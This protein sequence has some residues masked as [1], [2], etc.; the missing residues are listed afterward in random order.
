[1]RLS[2][3]YASVITILLITRARAPATPSRR[4]GPWHAMLVGEKTMP[5]VR[6]ILFPVDFSHSCLTVAR[7]VE[8]MA[9]LFEAEI[10][11]FNVVGMGEG[12]LTLAEERLPRR[13][14]Q[15][16]AFLA[17]ELK[18]FTTERICVTGD[19]PATEI[20][21]AAQRWQPDLVMMPT[22]G[23]GA[24]RSLL[25]GSVTAKILHDLDCPVWTSVHSEAVL[26]LEQIHCRR[27]LCAVNLGDRSRSVLQ[28]AAALA[29]DSKADL[30]I[31][32]ATPALSA[33]YAGWALEQEF[34]DS[35]SAQAK[36]RI[37]KLQAV[38]GTSA[39]VFIGA[40]DP[41]EVIAGATGEFEADL[42]VIGRHDD[43]GIAG[44][45]QQNAYAIL[46]DSPCP[47]ISI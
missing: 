32:H 13:Q 20:V 36:D 9:G 16:N 45:L 35:V 19:D 29:A 37:E 38:A 2:P 1:M 24:F 26:P 22:H 25:L 15:L 30:A 12:G 3:F 46:R 28:W 41:A 44:R 10:T 18:Y 8:F 31:V 34:A 5:L 14:A 23:L 40:G 33:G 7:Y 39:R 42:L 4:F 11:M 47:V 43:T 21:A 27:I 17:D 6:K